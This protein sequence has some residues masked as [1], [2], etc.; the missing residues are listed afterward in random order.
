MSDVL[1]Y[2][3]GMPSGRR[4]LLM[5]LA[6]FA[7]GE[8]VCWPSIKSLAEDADLGERHVSAELKTL[9]K[10]GFITIVEVPG[11]SNHYRIHIPQGMNC[12]SGVRCAKGVNHS[13]GVNH[14]ASRTTVQGRGEPQ[15]TPGDEPQDTPTTLN[16]HKTVNE[17]SVRAQ[18]AA[19]PR[20]MRYSP[21]FEEFWEAYPKKKSKGEAFKAWNQLRPDAGLRER[22]IGA[23]AR[24][25]RS[26]DWREANGKYIPFPASWIRDEGWEDVIE[27]RVEQARVVAPVP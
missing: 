18:A 4:T 9:A 20:V 11:K 7:N 22:M 24:L 3:H 5:A 12:G 14:S 6:N 21:E 17:P 25:A 19:Q 23:V 26:S 2:V 16:R 1:R 8:G 27:V 13:S 10:D 15:C